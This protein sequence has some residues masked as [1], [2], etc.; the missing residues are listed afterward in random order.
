MCVKSLMDEPLLSF[1]DLSVV[2]V[3]IRIFV[4][5][6]RF[7]TQLIFSEFLLPDVIRRSA[8]SW[9]SEQFITGHLADLKQKKTKLIKNITLF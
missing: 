9:T 6:S 8:V 3:G 2:P 4:N 7:F 5:S 1:L